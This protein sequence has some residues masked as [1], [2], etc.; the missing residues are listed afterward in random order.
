MEAMVMRAFAVGEPDGKIPF[1]GVGAVVALPR[2]GGHTV[3]VAKVLYVREE[4]AGDVDL[5]LDVDQ[6]SG[7]RIEL[8]KK[9]KVIGLEVR[10]RVH[11]GGC[12][13]GWRVGARW[14]RCG[15]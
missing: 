2:A 9:N 6:E 11:H 1:A 8:H 13:R 4:L 3:A 7:G 5:A 14:C 15:C 10:R 12:V